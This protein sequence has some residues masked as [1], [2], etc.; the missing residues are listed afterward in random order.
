LFVYRGAMNAHIALIVVIVER[1]EKCIMAVHSPRLAVFHC[2]ALYV[3][4]VRMRREVDEVL[5]VLRA[6]VA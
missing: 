4:E 5:M 3:A 6:V 1:V 2:V